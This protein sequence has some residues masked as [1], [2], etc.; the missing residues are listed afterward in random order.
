MWN[1]NLIGKKNTGGG[2]KY[3]WLLKGNVKNPYGDRNY[4][5]CVASTQNYISDSIV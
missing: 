1:T 2:G 5:Y 3:V 4:F